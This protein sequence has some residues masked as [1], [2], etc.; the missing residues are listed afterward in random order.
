MLGEAGRGLIRFA[1]FAGLMDRA[2]EVNQVVSMVQLNGPADG[3][4]FADKWA[5]PAVDVTAQ[6]AENDANG[7][8]SGHA[9]AITAS[10]ALQPLER[11]TVKV[12]VA[13]GN[14]SIEGGQ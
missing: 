8:E 14:L 3:V 1:E 2:P 10:D 6:S 11:P 4:S 9:E 5:Q 7:H 13:E 12:A